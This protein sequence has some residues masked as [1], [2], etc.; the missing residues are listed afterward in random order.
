MFKLNP[1][2]KQ[3]IQDFTDK[4]KNIG[5]AY[6][7]TDGF[8]LDTLGMGGMTVARWVKGRRIAIDPSVPHTKA[9]KTVINYLKK[10]TPKNLIEE[11]TSSKLGA[12][13]QEIRGGSLDEE[14]TKRNDSLMGN[15]MDLLD[16]LAEHP[17]LHAR[18]DHKAEDDARS[19][20]KRFRVM[21]FKMPWA[22][23]GDAV[24]HLDDALRMWGFKGSREKGY[25]KKSHGGRVDVD[26]KP[27]MMI[28]TAYPG[29]GMH[30]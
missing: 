13:L 21:V 1:R 29:T 2:D 22:D 25:S 12:L 11:S 18:R 20:S 14:A 23:R 24:S 16:D 6:M 15:L 10:V 3:V 30:F 4:K 17:K 5:G 8:R 9:Q 19:T 7:W 26:F 28:I 27:R